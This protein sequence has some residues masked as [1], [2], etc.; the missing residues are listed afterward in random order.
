[1][2]VSDRE[3]LIHQHTIRSQNHPASEKS[4][5]KGKKSAAPYNIDVGDIVYLYSDRDKSRAR[6]RYL[7]VSIDGKWCFVKKFSGNQLH[8]SSYKVKR[9]ECYLLP[10]D[11]SL[12]S[13][14]HITAESTD[15]EDNDTQYT[16]SAPPPKIVDVPNILIHPVEN[17][18]S[19]GN[20]DSQYDYPII[21][22]SPQEIATDSQP[23]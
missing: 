2:P 4:K 17:T 20:N 22:P 3:N 5:H 9:E 23:N 7:M 19:Q 6:S 12:L 16:K 15:D 1:M 13:H 21:N 10:N 18:P 11:F 14:H 8:S